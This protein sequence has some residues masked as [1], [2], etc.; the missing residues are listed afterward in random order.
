MFQT[1]FPSIIRSSK[2][3]IQRQ[4][5]V[6]PILLCRWQYRSD[7]CLTLCVQFWAP[8]DGRKN[9]LKHVKRCTEINR[10]WN[11][12]SCWLHSA[13]ILATHG[14]VNVLIRFENKRTWNISSVNIFSDRISSLTL[15]FMWYYL[16]ISVRRL[17]P[18]LEEEFWQQTHNYLPG[19]V[20]YCEHFV[21]PLQKLRK[22]E[23]RFS[24]ATIQRYEVTK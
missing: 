13:N 3:H 5:F 7:K 11:V 23:T 8:D 18:Q 4:A 6:R 10:L 19:A 16:I 24:S 1:V 17:W 9:R 21:R 2:L 12:A 15:P 22:N 20:L 14:P